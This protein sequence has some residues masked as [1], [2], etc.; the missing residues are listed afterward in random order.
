MTVI[1][2]NPGAF[3]TRVHRVYLEFRPSM[4]QPGPQ[5]R[6]AIPACMA[7]VFPLRRDPTEF[8]VVE[9]GGEAYM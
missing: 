8:N 1:V 2:P 4:C 7:D 3:R 5:R 9:W 6:V